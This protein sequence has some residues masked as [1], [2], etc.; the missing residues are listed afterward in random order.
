MAAS[1]EIP[2]FIDQGDQSQTACSSKVHAKQETT[3]GPNDT[4]KTKDCL[5]T[6]S[7]TT[8]TDPH[9]TLE[10]VF[11][12]SKLTT[13][14]HNSGVSRPGQIFR[15]GKEAP[16]FGSRSLKDRYHKDKGKTKA[17]GLAAL[18]VNL[19]TDEAPE[20]YERHYIELIR[21]C[22]EELEGT[23][24]LVSKYTPRG[25]NYGGIF[26][27]RTVEWLKACPLVWSPMIGIAMEG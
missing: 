25:K 5:P 16:I 23:G 11:T 6:S 24:I 10:S 2:K 22:R 7:A 13:P 27:P 17:L 19:N 18:F 1:N 12:V 9:L 3:T 20:V 15:T 8:S 4:I 26:G 14:Y 21:K